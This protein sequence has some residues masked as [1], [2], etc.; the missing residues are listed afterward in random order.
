MAEIR[1]GQSPY[2]KAEWPDIG[3]QHNVVDLDS[4]RPERKN[5][6]LRRAHVREDLLGNPYITVPTAM[7]LVPSQSAS[8]TVLFKR[9][10]ARCVG[11]GGAFFLSRQKK[12]GLV[13]IRVLLLTTVYFPADRWRC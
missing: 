4:S 12:H 3:R 11:I 13:R 7:T 1:T 9:D 10:Q 8:F 6:I 5:D 2:S